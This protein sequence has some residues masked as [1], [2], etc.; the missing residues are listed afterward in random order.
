MFGL[1]LIHT[2]SWKG[3]FYMCNACM[4]RHTRRTRLRLLV[5]EMIILNVYCV[6]EGVT[7]PA[8]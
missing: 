4:L 8:M 2:V 1:S 7:F 5:H 6:W 3:T